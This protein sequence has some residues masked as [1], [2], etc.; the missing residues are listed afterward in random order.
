[1]EERFSE[2]PGESAQKTQISVKRKRGCL[3]LRQTCS[4]YEECPEKEGKIFIL[5]LLLALVTFL[6]VFPMKSGLYLD[7]LAKS[8]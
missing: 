2:Q 5:F 1:V 3:A 6:Q 7:S 4:P 8:G